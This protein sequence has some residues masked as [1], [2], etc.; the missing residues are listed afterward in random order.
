[1]L[2]S[3]L[4]FLIFV[5]GLCAVLKTFHEEFCLCLRARVCV[6][7]GLCEIEHWRQ[8]G[9]HSIQGLAFPYKMQSACNL[10]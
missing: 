1:M 6:C 10:D 2:N 8:F 9:L 7:I 3:G 4:G 5:L